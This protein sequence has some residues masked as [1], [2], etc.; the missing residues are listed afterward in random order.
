MRGSGL[1]EILTA[2]YKCVSNMLN[3]KAQPKAQRGMVVTALL[4]DCVMSGNNTHEE[5]EAILQSARI[6]K[7]GRMWV[8]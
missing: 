3:G 6:S 2:A 7:T 4:A 8:D 5:I 1:E